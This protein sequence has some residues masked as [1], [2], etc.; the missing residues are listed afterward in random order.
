MVGAKAGRARASARD[1][2]SELIDLCRERG[3]VRLVHQGTEIVLGP[4]PP[5]KSAK[6]EPTDAQLAHRRDY[7]QNMLGRPVSIKELEHLP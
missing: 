3:V 4:P 2:L 5:P 1:E 6:A 7:Y